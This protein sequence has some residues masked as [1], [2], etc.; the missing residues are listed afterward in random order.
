MM[1]QQYIIR[2]M[3]IFFF[4]RMYIYLHF[5][6]EPEYTDEELQ[7]MDAKKASGE[8]AYLY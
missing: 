6:N 5:Y 8:S 4:S 7:Q 1:R 2:L 3:V